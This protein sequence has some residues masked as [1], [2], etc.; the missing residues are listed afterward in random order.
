MNR[1]GRR[2]AV[3]V[4]GLCLAF[5]AAEGA[6]SK[7]ATEPALAW[8]AVPFDAPEVPEA[9]GLAP[10]SYAPGTFW[11]NND[12]FN[13]A[14]I[15][16][17]DPTAGR[18]VQTLRVAAPE[19]WDWEDIAAFTWHGSPWLLLADTG[20]NLSS[21]HV[22]VLNILPEPP[23]PPRVVTFAPAWR[24][25]VDFPGGFFTGAPDIE[26]VAVHDDS[27][28]LVSKRESPPRLWRVPLGQPGPE[29]G[30]HAVRAV[31]LGV[32]A[33]PRTGAPGS[34]RDWPTALAFSPDGRRAVLVTYRLAHLWTRAPGDSW[35]TA[36]LA[37]P[38]ASFELPGN[39]RHRGRNPGRPGAA[40]GRCRRPAAAG[41]SRHTARIAK[42]SLTHRC[43]SGLPGSCSK[44]A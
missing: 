16:R 42:A 5:V 9:S 31:A 39:Q 26:A 27:V 37:P 29:A 13:P 15:Y 14:E 41:F 12:S 30:L 3:A 35:G 38:E 22:L 44:A 6:A 17:L 43:A 21:R 40:L 23:P 34:T 2:E 28:Y 4:L 10:S 1:R 19:V 8:Q 32:L 18:V 24:I 36:L 11:V 7:L 25:L 33:L 20:N